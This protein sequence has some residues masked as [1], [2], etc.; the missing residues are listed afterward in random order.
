MQPKGRIMET[1]TLSFISGIDAQTIFLHSITKIDEEVVGTGPFANVCVYA[2][3][4]DGTKVP[5][6]KSAHNDIVERQKYLRIAQRQLQ[7]RVGATKALDM[8]HYSTSLVE[9][10]EILTI[11][12]LEHNKKLV[13]RGAK[14]PKGCEY[15]YIHGNR[16]EAD[17]VHKSVWSMYSAQHDNSTKKTV[18]I[19]DLDVP[20][21]K[22]EEIK[23]AV[24]EFFDRE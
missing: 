23:T 14:T 18:Y 20:K 4:V 5:I 6:F 7:L 21:E 12:G 11:E 22:W 16:P 10:S 13:V 8:P 9:E 24:N 2:Y 3:L 15:I 17:V 19:T 1:N